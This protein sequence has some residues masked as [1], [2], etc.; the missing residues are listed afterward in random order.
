MQK[1]LERIRT[2]IKKGKAH[3]IEILAATQTVLWGLWLILP[4][5]TF[6]TSLAYR[7]MGSIAPELLWGYSMF[8]LGIL[9]FIGAFFLPQPIKK[10]IIIQSIFAWVT[11]CLSFSFSSITSTAVPQAAMGALVQIF[12]LDY[13]MRG[14]I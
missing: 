13:N 14:D 9:E 10:V 8:W 11:I 5:E 4:Q 1:I 3:R 2:C 7:Y 12:A 6:S